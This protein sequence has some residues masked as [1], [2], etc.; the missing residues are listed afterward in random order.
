MKNNLTRQLKPNAITALCIISESEIIK[1]MPEYNCNFEYDNP[2][3]FKLFLF[4][5]GMDI[6]QD[7][8]R[9]DAIQHRNGLNEIVTCS[10]W[11]GQER[12]DSDWIRS[13]YASQQAKDKASGSRILEDLYRS[14]HLTEDAQ[15]RIAE[16][17][18]IEIMQQ[19]KQQMKE[20]NAN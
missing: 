4:G 12:L 3:R 8:E 11:V 20:T 9:Q 17:E 10:R 2:T 16:R 18:K 7:I 6:T 15:A 19:L 5:L 14:K 1:V 13:G